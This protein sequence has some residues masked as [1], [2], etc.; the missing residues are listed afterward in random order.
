MNQHQQN[1]YNNN[2]QK[3]PVSSIAIW[4]NSGIK[5]FTGSHDGYWRLWN[6]AGGNFGKEF[7]SNMSGKVYQVAVHQHFLFC[8]FEAPVVLNGGANNSAT[9]TATTNNSTSS[10]HMI[11]GA[12][13]GMVHAWNLQNPLLPPAELQIS[14]MHH[15][16]YAHNQA[17]TALTIHNA[18][19][20]SGSMDGSIR[21]WAFENGAFMLKQS[22]PGHARQ[23]TGLVFPADS[24]LLWSSSIDGSI[25]IWNLSTGDCQYVITANT[26]GSSSGNNARAGNNSNT[27]GTGIGH[28]AAVTALKSFEIPSAGTF[29]LSASL[30][31][32]IKA[33]NGTTGECVAS[34]AH[35]EGVLC[36]SLVQMGGN[37]LLMVGLESGI[38]MCRNLV[39]TKKV[40]AFGLLFILSNTH[41]VAHS[42]ACMCITS[43]P[44]GTFYTGGADGQMLV[45][46]ITGDLGLE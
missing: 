9:S 33:W 7:E 17:V 19:V 12:S 38:V 30:D 10:G 39:Q 1:N 8:A 16:P 26:A 15:L 2:N 31:G 36:M 44:S 3:H 21:V 28:T 27:T 37:P 22:L 35:G 11:S 25:R 29:I 4:E 32:T 6:T 13:V 40:P 46:Q 23:V 5:I 18:T 34:E 41:S 45:F 24:N 43:G 42:G 20:V 14:P